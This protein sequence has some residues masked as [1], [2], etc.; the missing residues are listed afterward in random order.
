[1]VQLGVQFSSVIVAR[2]ANHTCHDIC[3][4]NKEL[5]IN[6]VHNVAIIVNIR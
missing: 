4:N 1:M 5:R 2:H 6:V 3:D